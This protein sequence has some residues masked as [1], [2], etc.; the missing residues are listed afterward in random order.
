VLDPNQ[1]YVAFK[2]RDTGLGISKDKQRII[3][4]AFQQAEGSTS[5][6]YGGTGLGLSISRGLASLLGG[7]IDLESELNKGSTFS[8]Y[9]PMKTHHYGLSEFRELTP[10]S[11]IMLSTS[12]RPIK[13]VKA[14]KKD[15]Q[16]IV[17]D[18]DRKNIKDGD[19]VMLIIEGDPVMA[20]MFI[21][22]VRKNG[23]KAVVSINSRNIITMLKEFIP[24]AM[25]ID[26][27]SEDLI[28]Q[29]VLN[30]V[31]S[32]LNMRHIPVGI[33]SLASG[34]FDIKKFG[35]CFLART[36][37][38]KAIDSM[39][40]ELT[41]YIEKKEKQVLIV[42]EDVKK[43]EKIKKTLN[44][45]GL[46]LVNVNRK[47]DAY[48]M[49]EMNHFDAMLIFVNGKGVELVKRLSDR[50]E[51]T[52]LIV[53]TTSSIANKEEKDMREISHAVITS[54]GG[55]EQFLI[56]QLMLNL[57]IPYDRLSK[58]VQDTIKRVH[59]SKDFLIDKKILVVDDDIR[60][61]FALTSIFEQYNS[62]IFSAE[63][64]KEALHV[65][66]KHKNM[67]IVLMDIMMPDMNGY[68]TIQEIRKLKDFKNLPI[69]A[70]TAKAMPEDR[71]KCIKAGASEYITK[72]IDTDE[73]ISIIKYFV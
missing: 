71:A 12:E 56:D 57:H 72:P 70:V 16:V 24:D 43:V 37:N 52:P 59:N 22:K 15:P 10:T 20:S 39:L 62:H 60:N 1:N 44:I 35:K 14:P 65:L 2:I 28:G 53:N 4:E 17:V 67:D 54:N 6:K 51:D 27:D 63:G 38:P 18:D 7:F 68:Q 29:K 50:H 33:T 40:D 55:S 42:S 58:D 11:D 69:I 9:I 30:Q 49:V 26:F 47:Q 73:L 19:K 34:K 5:R 48:E 23:Y 61:I 32:N 25:I 21:D 3:F 41:Q 13:E 64:G 36:N 45:D 31:K 46:K 66:S 8:L